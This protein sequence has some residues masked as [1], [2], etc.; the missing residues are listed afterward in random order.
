MPKNY[1]LSLLAALLLLPLLAIGC[2]EHQEQNPPSIV[3]PERNAFWHYTNSIRSGLTRMVVIKDMQNS[4]I[5]MISFI[6]PDDQEYNEDYEYNFYE[7]DFPKSNVVRGAHNNMSKYAVEPGFT[8]TLGNKIEGLKTDETDLIAIL[9]IKSEEEC[10]TVE[11]NVTRNQDALIPSIETNI[12]ITPLNTEI[13]G[14]QV[15]TL[16][17]KIGCVRAPNGLFLYNMLLER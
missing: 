11:R 8:I 16:P 2:D 3:A 9:P 13:L 10:Q 1:K 15:A 6:L 17:R 14:S 7:K 12:N 5:S 4:E